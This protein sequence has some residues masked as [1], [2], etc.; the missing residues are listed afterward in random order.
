MLRYEVSDLTS[1]DL[2]KELEEVLGKKKLAGLARLPEPRANE[3]YRDILAKL[4]KNVGICQAVVWVEESS[5]KRTAY[6]FILRSAPKGGE[7][8]WI[9]APIRIEGCKIE[10]KEGEIVK[11]DYKASEFQE[12]RQILSRIE[13]VAEEY[14]EAE[15]KLSLERALSFD[16][17]SW[18]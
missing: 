9:E 13:E 16:P 11:T 15:T 4:Y 10:F 6:V 14:Q 1:M 7:G 12:A 17:Y 5:G 2:L 3:R 8:S 18:S